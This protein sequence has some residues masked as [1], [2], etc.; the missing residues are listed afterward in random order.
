MSETDVVRIEAQL[1]EIRALV[2][3]I[4]RARP[5]PSAVS[6]KEA[7]RLLSCSPKH[8]GRMVKRG[9]LTPRDLDGVRRIPVS[10]IHDLLEG[11]TMASSGATPAQVRFDGAAA[12]RKLKEL[13]SKR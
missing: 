12:M 2:A 5:H 9:T 6:L 1:L 11:P 10:Q 7:A 8:I 4:G 13:R 3:T